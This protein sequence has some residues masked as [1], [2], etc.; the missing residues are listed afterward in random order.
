MWVWICVSSAHAGGREPEALDR[1]VEIGRP[2]GAA[3][4]QALAQR[5]LVDL[6]DADAGR[7]EVGHLVADRQRDLA[8]G[9]R[10]AAGRRARTTSCRMV[11]GPVSM[12]FIGLSVSDCA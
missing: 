4:R 8:A 10:R 5:R 2:V 9:R 3:Q 1:P 6:D 11:T 7:F 12:P